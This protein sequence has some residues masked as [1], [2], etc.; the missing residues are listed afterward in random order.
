MLRQGYFGGVPP[1]SPVPSPA[2]ARSP[3]RR[4]PPEATEAAPAT[5]KRRVNDIALGRFERW[6]L[7]KMAARLPRW[8]TPDGLTALALVGALAAGLAYALAGRDLA[9]LHL[10][11]LGLVV[12]WWGDS[13]DGTLARV[14]QIRRERY[15]FF[16][17]H[18]CDAVAVVVLAVGL[19]AGSL[20]RMDV[21]LAVGGAVLLFMVLVHLVTIG[22]DVFKISFGGVGPTELRL[23]AIVL[24]TVLWAVGPQP[25]LTWAPGWGLYDVV[26]LAVAVGLLAVFAV[27]AVRE[28][29]TMSRLDPTPAPGD[30]G[31][32][33]DPTGQARGGS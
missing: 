11:S 9:W 4:T 22:R 3:A 10:A 8:V 21:A 27:F 25:E 14:R 15:G 24:N 20:M 6:A 29:R 28:T 31:L 12:H 7:P 13:L 23:L 32:P 33:S 1:A 2:P 17:D 30:D 19:G 5:P 26:G 18:L 16:V